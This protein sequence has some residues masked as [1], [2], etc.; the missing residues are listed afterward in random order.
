LFL[1]GLALNNDRA[2]FQEHKT[3]YAGALA[4]F[5]EFL[6][7]LA[8][9]LSAFNPALINYNAKNSVYRIYRDLRFSRDKTPYNP[10]LRGRVAEGGKKMIPL[11]IYVQL[12]PG[13]TLIGCGVW[14]ETPAVTRRVRDAI[15]ARDQEFY[16]IVTA[17]GFDFT[18]EGDKLKNVP[19]EYDAAALCAE[20][21]KHKS[22][23][24]YRGFSDDALNGYDVLRAAAVDFYLRTRPFADFMNAALC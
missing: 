4:G 21:L 11:G 13:D 14:D 2:W 1:R 16:D 9:D 18:L 17:P 24:V 8:F 7:A 15:A 23:L 10:S 20:Y 6:A 22:W 3:E 5:E 19:K 12:K